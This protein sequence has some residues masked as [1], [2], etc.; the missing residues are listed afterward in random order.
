MHFL[1]RTIQKPAHCSGVGLHSG[2]AVNVTIYPAPINHGIKFR[3]IDLPDSPYVSAHFN[4]V[5]DTSLATVIG[6]EGCI[7]STIEHL[8]ASFAGL[9]IDN[10]LVELDAYEMPVMD[11]S[12]GPFIDLIKQ[13]GLVELEGPRSFFIIKEPIE[14]AQNGKSV[15]VYPH[16]TFKIT[17]EIEYDNPV[18]AKQSYSVEASDEIFEC[19][20]CRARTFGFLDDVAYSKSVGLARGGSLDNAVV[21][22]D[23]KVLNP[24]GLRFP[25]EFVRHKVLDCIGD[26]SLLGM[27]I[28]GHIKAKKSGHAFNH[29][30]LKKF[31]DQKESWETRTIND[32]CD[33]IPFLPR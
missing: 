24:E 22:D 27:P 6:H 21:I 18:I 17:C 25:D 5:V 7:V 13:A 2:K 30:F 16:P 10:A 33:L 32:I 19:E 11:G 29:A 8:M 15:G 26:F 3:R 23:E 28:I 14:L 31:F 4:M 9:S 20:I 12:A 1:Q